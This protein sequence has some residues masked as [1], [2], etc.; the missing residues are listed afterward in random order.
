LRD[1]GTLAAP[2]PKAD[3]G[4]WLIL[5]NFLVTDATYPQTEEA[6]VSYLGDRYSAED[7]KDAL[8][9]LFSGD[10]DD[11]IALANLRALKAIYIPQ[12]STVLANTTNV[13]KDLPVV[14]PARKKNRRLRR[15]FNVGAILTSNVYTKQQV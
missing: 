14:T 5:E 4:A 12:V 8:A 1:T 6:F 13:A 7:W 2:S 11:G 10:G 3:E 15:P 9:A